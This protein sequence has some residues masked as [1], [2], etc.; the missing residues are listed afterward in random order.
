L[1][2][3]RIRKHARAATAMQ[4][5]SDEIEQAIRRIERLMGGMT[6]ERLGRL[7]ADLAVR[8]DEWLAVR[9]LPLTDRGRMELIAWAMVLQGWDQGPENHVR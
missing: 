5:P 1:V 8:P 6:R 7:L 2:I 3:S 9:G 4:D